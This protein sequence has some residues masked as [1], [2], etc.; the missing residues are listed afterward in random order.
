MLELLAEKLFLHFATDQSYY[1][2]QQDDGKYRKKPG[3]VSKRFIEE[4]LTKSRS[5]AIYQKN[6]DQTIKWICFD[7]DIKKSQM[8]S[9]DMTPALNELKRA[10]TAFCQRLNEYDLPYLL[11]F[12]GQRGFHIW[13]TFQEKVF[14]RLGYEILQAI[15]DKVNVSFDRNLI[16]I[17]LFPKTSSPTD[18]VGLGVKMPL[19]KHKSSGTY[20]I[21]LNSIEDIFNYKRVRSLE[22]VSLESQYQILNDHQSS[23]KS[24]I[25]GKLGVSFEISSEEEFC[26]RIKSI[27]VQNEG[28][29]IQDLVAH[30]RTSKPLNEFVEKIITENKLSNEE[31]KLLVGIFANVTCRKNPSLNRKILHEIFSKTINYNKELSDAAITTLSS[32]HFPSQ[33]RIEKTLGI[34]FGRDLEVEELIKCCIPKYVSHTDA[35]L[36]FSSADISITRNA[37]LNYLFFNDEVQSR[38]TISE[39]SKHSIS[40]LHNSAL[41]VLKNPQEAKFYKHTRKES[42]KTRTLVSLKAPERILTSAILKQ[43][44]YLLD[45]DL[46]SNSYG[47]RPNKGF[48]NGYIFQPWL[49]HWIKFISNI[50]SLIQ[51]PDNAE[52]Y[53]VKA[54]IQ[55]F[56]DKI[57]HDNLKR[58]LLGDSNDR[59]SKKISGLSE[60]SHRIYEEYIDALFKITEKITKSRIGLPQGP[61]YAR[62]F[63][64]LFLDKIDFDFEDKIKNGHIYSY[65]RYVDDIFFIAQTE[66]L[67]KDTLNELNELLKLQGLELNTDKT[68]LS[69][70]KHF[71]GN[72]DEYTSKSKYVVD[73]FSKDYINATETQ[74]N[75]AINEF[76][77]IIYG[78]KAEDDLA[79]IYSHLDGI[80]NFDNWKINNLLPTIEKG[81][82]RGTVYKHL[83]NFILENNSTW[84]L[85]NSIEKL[86][87]L[88]SEIFSASV[89]NYIESNNT[90]IQSVL[91]MF[92]PLISKLELT[93]LVTEHILYMKLVFG[94]KINL[95]EFDSR[96]VGSCVISLSDHRDLHVDSDFIR[97]INTY[98]NDIKS[99]SSFIKIMYSLCSS[100]YL[101]KEDLNDLAGTFY[102][103]FADDKK[104]G[105]LRINSSLGIDCATT[106]IGR[107]HV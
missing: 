41:A 93:E 43:V 104:S 23:T 3:R 88:Q 39:L 18:G 90:Q 52:Y 78:D 75:L 71:G 21:L 6:I 37:E 99:Q 102:A 47:Y 10:V 107:A 73:Q 53:I 14:Y 61:A 79:F 51:D 105:G 106:E 42:S 34:K 84:S 94:A 91:D 69:Q 97:Y 54:D 87:E 77:R 101:S 48:K 30:W 82:G 31:R 70:V 50:N 4:A 76:S 57:P 80:T 11:E 19:S 68:V 7:F 24:E 40:E 89:I 74:K 29:D 22:E 63:A 60:D 8:Q 103:K 81:I 12:S 27:K 58:M 20:A 65:Q 9:S 32:F 67:A 35:A 85:L 15:L 95:D 26:T 5:F 64:E 83:F 96:I 59:I 13:I 45:L 33:E 38:L 16:D 44:I 17:D 28:F 86:T 56:Y 36:E 100:S 62:Y 2:E 66:S 25:E 1:C 55:S 92:L 46:N 72:F 49:Y 98:L